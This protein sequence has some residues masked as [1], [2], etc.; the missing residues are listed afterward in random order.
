M[1]SHWYARE[2]DSVQI[3]KRTEHFQCPNT[4]LDGSLFTSLPIQAPEKTCFTTSMYSTEYG[5]A[6]SM[7]INI[8]GQ[9]RQDA[10]DVQSQKKID[11]FSGERVQKLRKGSGDS[12]LSED[13]AEDSERH[14]RHTKSKS[15]D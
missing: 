10:F 7:E 14:A 13:V 11:C 8:Q 12:S 9:K 2:I 3:V 1:S 4:V 15:G 5:T 6:S